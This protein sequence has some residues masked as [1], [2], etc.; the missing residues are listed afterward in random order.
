MDI[1]TQ[2]QRRPGGVPAQ[3]IDAAGRPQ[4]VGTMLLIRWRSGA[5]QRIR[6]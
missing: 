1:Q 5:W 3:R 2:S 6:I 4:A